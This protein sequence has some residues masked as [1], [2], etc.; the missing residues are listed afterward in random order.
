MPKQ[1]FAL[2]FLFLSRLDQY[3]A[4]DAGEGE[5]NVTASQLLSGH[6]GELI[7]VGVGMFFH[8]LDMKAADHQYVPAAK[9]DKIKRGEANHDGGMI[10]R[11]FA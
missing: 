4:F 11:C 7:P 8:H 2:F 6:S 1:P 5:A 3:V 9:Q 10:E